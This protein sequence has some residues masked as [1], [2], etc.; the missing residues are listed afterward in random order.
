MTITLPFLFMILHFSQIFLT[1]GL[2]FILLYQPFLYL[3]CTPGYASLCQVVYRHL[4]GYAVTGQNSDIV[5]S[6][7]SRN[8]RGHY[9]S[10]GK[11]YLEVGVGQSLNYRT[12]KFDNVI[13]R[14]NNPSSADYL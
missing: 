5:Y 7:L 9:V 14:Q 2:T 3:L 1:D 6:Q 13:L 4:N 8:V 10:V 12:L 11:L